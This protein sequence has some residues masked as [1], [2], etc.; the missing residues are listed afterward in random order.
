MGKSIIP[1]GSFGYRTCQSIMTR[2]TRNRSRKGVRISDYARGT[3]NFGAGSLSSNIYPNT[4]AFFRASRGKS[5]NANSFLFDI[6]EVRLSGMQDR[7][8]L[9]ANDATVPEVL[10]ALRRAI[11]LE[12]MLRGTVEQKFTGVYSGSVHYVLTRL[13]MGENY[14]LQTT[15][16]GISIVLLGQSVSD[17]EARPGLLALQRPRPPAPHIATPSPVQ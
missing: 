3:P 7:L 13:L 6:I 4:I 11:G 16:S 9:Q 12:V 1:S 2:R 14:I 10:A 8:V 17:D 15:S 5:I